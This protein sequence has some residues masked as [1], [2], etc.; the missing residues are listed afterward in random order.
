MK[1]YYKLNFR[2]KPE[3]GKYDGKIYF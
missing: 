3:K 2:D 1:F